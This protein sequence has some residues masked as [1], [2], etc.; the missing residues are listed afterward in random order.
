MEVRGW[1]LEAADLIQ[2]GG[3]LFGLAAFMVR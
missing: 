2:I 1:T 3:F